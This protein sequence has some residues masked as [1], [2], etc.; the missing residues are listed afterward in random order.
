MS[1]LLTQIRQLLPSIMSQT[2]WDQGAD[3]DRFEGYLFALVLQA[4]GK[5]GAT[6]RFENRKGPSTESRPFERHPDTC[7]AISVLTPTQ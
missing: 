1:A 2:S 3:E 7:G 6:V 5:E 4:A